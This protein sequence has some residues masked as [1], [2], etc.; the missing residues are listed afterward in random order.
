MIRATS[1]S[2]SWTRSSI[3]WLAGISHR[4]NMLAAIRRQ[5]VSD[6]RANTPNAASVSRPACWID[7]WSLSAAARK[8]AVIEL[9][10][11]G[12][13]A[14]GTNK[15]AQ[16]TRGMA[17]RLLG[18]AVVRA[19]RTPSFVRL[20]DATVRCGDRQ[21]Q[22]QKDRDANPGLVR[23]LSSMTTRQAAPWLL[24]SSCPAAT[25]RLTHRSTE[26]RSTSRARATAA[27]E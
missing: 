21:A 8:R 22:K 16:E 6:S 20:G 10:R 19:A 23:P 4:R 3:S 14:F 2:M 15:K 12:F 11:F 13:F 18:F 24:G 5:S 27:A 25:T 1:P 17:R 26:L 7:A 9:F